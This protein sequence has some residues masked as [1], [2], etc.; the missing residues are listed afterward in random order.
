MLVLLVVALLSDPTCVGVGAFVKVTAI[1]PK[2]HEP[3]SVYHTLT[4]QC[5]YPGTANVNLIM[6]STNESLVRRGVNNLKNCL[7]PP[8]LRQT[9]EI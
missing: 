8:S 3:L 7:E 4:T 6:A 2:Y 1:L 9:A 5:P